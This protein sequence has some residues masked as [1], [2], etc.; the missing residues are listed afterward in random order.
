MPSDIK[1][2]KRPQLPLEYLP[3]S[4]SEAI[5]LAKENNIALNLSRINLKTLKIQ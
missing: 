4:E 3:E 1:T 5:R 2:F